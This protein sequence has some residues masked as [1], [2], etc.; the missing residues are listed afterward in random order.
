MTQ[1]S[2]NSPALKPK[3]YSRNEHP[4]SRKSIDPDA[5]KIMYRLIT[6]GF[7]AYL[8]GGGVRDLLLGK[9]PKDFDI[10]TNAT[11]KQI[12]SLFRNSRIIGR[13]FRLIHV[14]FKDNKI[15]EVATFRAADTPVEEPET[16]ETEFESN[17][18]TL[19]D[20]NIFGTDATDAIR[21]DITINALF[22][23]LATF[24]I[25]DYVGGYED[26][27]AKLVR[28]IGDPDKRLAEDSV[29]LIRVVRHAARAGFEIE[30]ACKAAVIRNAYLLKKSPAV[31]VYVEF[32][33]DLTSGCLLQILRLLAETG[34]LEHFFPELAAHRELLMADGS[35]LGEGLSRLDQAVK[36]GKEVPV[37]PILALLF[38][39]AGTGVA[40]ANE[41]ADAMQGEDC[42]QDLIANASSILALP[43]KEKERIE[44]VLAAWL[45]LET[46]GPSDGLL[47]SLARRSSTGDLLILCDFLYGPEDARTLFVRGAGEQRRHPDEYDDQRPRRRRRNR[48]RGPRRTDEAPETI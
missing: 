38:L 34:V 24:S 36:D 8:V 47:R 39:Y 44:K 29:R 42:I 37:T 22:Y 1:N 7:K 13:R 31:R 40:S 23:D 28:I 4:V 16:L 43:R 19:I 9:Q 18:P 26:L 10:A 12:R 48:R 30:P 21:R 20:D 45:D 25:I 27:K 3:I 15:V 5:V 46:S 33:K 14:Y 2:P 11:P 35:G 6:E 41:L 17:K 32:V